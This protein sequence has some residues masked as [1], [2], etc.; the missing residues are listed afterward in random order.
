MRGKEKIV[1][2]PRI[3]LLPCCVM[4]APQI[5]VLFVWVRI[6]SGQQKNL[7]PMLDSDFFCTFAAVKPMFNFM[8][9][10]YPTLC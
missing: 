3:L 6:L 1:S 5:L 4:V 2:L 7:N 8:F 10:K 9:H